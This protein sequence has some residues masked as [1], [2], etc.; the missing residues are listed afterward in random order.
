M[1]EEF[2]QYELE[3]PEELAGMYEVLQKSEE[4]E[5]VRQ[6]KVDEKLAL[7]QMCREE[8]ERCRNTPQTELTE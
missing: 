1:R 5:I 6:K 8:L 4:I 3:H 2:Y 7:I